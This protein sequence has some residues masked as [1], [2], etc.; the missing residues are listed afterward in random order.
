MMELKI[1]FK[2]AP[3]PFPIKV[4]IAPTIKIPKTGIP[5]LKVAASIA[6]PNG[7]I[8]PSIDN[9]DIQ[10]VKINKMIF[11]PFNNSFTIKRILLAL[12][13]CSFA[14]SVIF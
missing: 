13:S 4:P 6:N 10:K 11:F 2:K 9:V 1:K 8:S 5:E 12:F 7:A 14:L 3:T